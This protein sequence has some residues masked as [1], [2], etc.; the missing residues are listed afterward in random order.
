MPCP[1]AN[2]WREAIEEIDPD[3]RHLAVHEGHLARV[4]DRDRPAVTAGIELL[5]KVSFTGTAADLRDR[6]AQ[7]RDVGV[8]EIA[9]QPAGDDIPGELER[10]INA[11]G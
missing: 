3:R 11:V 8:T 2:C 4:T 9:Y 6:V 5:S 10:F 7:L 1:A